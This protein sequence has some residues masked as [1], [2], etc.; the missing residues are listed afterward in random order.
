MKTTFMKRG[1]LLLGSLCI[2]AT[3]FTSCEEETETLT[4]QTVEPTKEV[5]AE[6]LTEK[7][8][9]DKTG[10]LTEISFHGND[11]KVEDFGDHYVFEGDIRISKEDLNNQQKSTGR[12][13]DRWPFNTVHYAIESSLPNKQ[14]VYDAIAHWEAN[15]NLRFIKRTNQ[16]AYVYFRFGSG[17]SSEV[18]RMGRRQDII[19]ANGCSTGSTIHE[20]GHA[21]GLWHEQSRK[22]RDSY[23]T[24][25]WGNI[26][27]GK[28]HNFQT[29][30]QR[31]RDGT[32]YTSYLDFNSIMLYG[33]YAFSK[34]WLPTITKK[35]G[36]TYSVQRTALSYGDRYGISRMYPYQSCGTED[37]L[38]FNPNN[39]RIIYRFPNYIVTDGTSSMF[40]APNYS[41]A[42]QIINILRRY[43][44]RKTC[45]VSRPNPG[46]TYLLGSYSASNVAPAAGEDIIRFNPKNIEVKYVSGRWKIVDGYSYL[47][48]FGS[49]QAEARKALCMI[50][51]HKFTGIGYVG[52][53]NASLQY[54]VK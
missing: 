3:L 9:P 20:I 39:L 11:L 41:E 42:S 47:F 7:A 17:C 50:L 19:L 23:I 31:G 21:V 54:M 1:S 24:I 33:P 10:K 18:G 51:K 6:D 16:S 37:C 27:S 13:Y 46:L 44:Y 26:E 53:P 2:L 49:D 29:Y 8:Y 5:I 25:N 43:G 4:E 34:N 48:D 15:T 38:S 40:A 22:D 14:R 28:T 32:E 45:Y 12:I 35:D 36:S 52:R 30:V